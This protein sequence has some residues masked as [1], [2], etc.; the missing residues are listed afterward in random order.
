MNFKSSTINQARYV[1]T[2]EFEQ[3]IKNIRLVW[4]L[5]QQLEYDE[6]EQRKRKG[7]KT[8]YRENYF[9]LVSFFS[10]KHKIETITWLENV[11]N[12]KA[13]SIGSYR[14]YLKKMKNSYNFRIPPNLKIS[15]VF[16]RSEQVNQ[17]KKEFRIIPSIFFIQ[18]HSDVL[19][20][21]NINQMEIFLQ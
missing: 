5:T 10:E 16:E 17:K 2:N 20:L 3:E 18:V 21:S 7:K 19:C 6:N 15:N 8:S 4:V 11:D 1:N 12:G 9:P 13:Y 14:G